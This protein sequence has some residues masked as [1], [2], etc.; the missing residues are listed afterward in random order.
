VLNI[1]S[2][3]IGVLGSASEIQRC[4]QTIRIDGVGQRLK[5]LEGAQSA[6]EQLQALTI[7][8]KYA[9]NRRPPLGDRT[10]QLE[11]GT[12]LQPFGGHDDL[13]RVGAQQIEAVALVRNRIDG[14]QIT[15][16]SGDHLVAGGILVDDEHTHAGTVPA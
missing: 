16:R 4:D 11:P 5:Q 12:V 6:L 9:Q 10:E 14:V 1:G 13:E 15:Q 8:C 3:C 2:I 7:G